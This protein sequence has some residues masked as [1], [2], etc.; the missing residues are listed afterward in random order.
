MKA[1]RATALMLVAAT[2]APEEEEIHSDFEEYALGPTSGSRIVSKTFSGRKSL[3]DHHLA[4][5]GR[6]ERNGPKLGHHPTGGY[7]S[8]SGRWVPPSDATKSGVASSGG[9]GPALMPGRTS[10]GGNEDNPF[11]DGRGNRH[12]RWAARGSS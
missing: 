9:S 2:E 1:M 11:L 4:T 10:R 8:G 3:L 6:G 7:M 5:V 12:C